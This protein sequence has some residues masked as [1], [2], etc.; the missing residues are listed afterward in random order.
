MEC[1]C[2]ENEGKC[3]AK[4]R[5]RMVREKEGVADQRRFR[6]STEVWLLRVLSSWDVE[7]R[8]PSMIGFLDEA[9]WEGFCFHVS[10]F[11]GNPCGVGVKAK[12]KRTRKQCRDK[13]K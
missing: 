13:V 6:N 10:C 5:W 1:T 9:G 4:S 11:G 3:W 8:R 7:T 2:A 12:R